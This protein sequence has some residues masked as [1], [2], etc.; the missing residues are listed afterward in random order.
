MRRAHRLS[1]VVFLACVV[2]AGA[3]TPP[4]MEQPKEPWI[5]YR[6]NVITGALMPLESIYT[7]PERSGNSYY[8]YIP[9]AASTVEFP[10]RE[11]QMYVMRVGGLKDPPKFENWRSIVKL[12]RLSVGKDRRYATKNYVPMDVTTYGEVTSTVDKKNKT[13]YWFTL[14]LTARQPLPPGE[15]SVGS[16]LSSPAGFQSMHAQAFQIVE[17]M[18][19]TQRAPLPQSLPQAVSSSPDPLHLGA[20]PS[21]ATS[22]VP[23]E[24]EARAPSATATLADGISQARSGDYV[25]ALVTLNDVVSQMASRPAQPATLARAHAYRAVALIGLGQVEWAQAAVLQALR[26]DP[27]IAV[28]ATEFGARVAALFDSARRPARD[29]EA[30]GQAAE[31]AGRFQDAFLVYLS[32]IQSLPEPPLPADD[33]RLREKI[34]KVVQKLET[35]PRVPEEAMTHLAKGKALLDSGMAPGASPAS[36]AE[37]AVIELRKAVRIA[38]WW[39]DAMVQLAMALQQSGR[40]DDA[41]VNLDLYQLADPQGYAANGGSAS[42]KRVE[43]AERSR[44]RGPEPTA[45]APA[46]IHV[47]FPHAARARGVRAKVLCDGQVVADLANGRFVVL[48]A[49]PG[50]HNFEFKGKKAAASFEGGKEHYIRVGIEG[51]PAHLALR[52]T[53]PDKAAAEMRE[54]ELAANEQKHTFSAACTGV[55]T[56]PAR[57][58]F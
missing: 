29:P 50:F 16:G 9:G 51:Y 7:K 32:A 46:V 54:K 3:Q 14:L 1:L 53:D 43:S 25:N 6:I 5:A 49:P 47:Y 44:P 27:R 55:A 11:P 40:L 52:I 19:V 39:P 15:Y 10:S 37:R 36:A 56:A 12:E 24:V 18:A 45:I 28:D 21:T 23:L 57:Q 2:P 42:S 8:S 48:N 20:A 34:I 30:A 35:R 58:R 31:A 41:L 13:V 38:P 4:V 17:G 26:A 33:Q 22:S